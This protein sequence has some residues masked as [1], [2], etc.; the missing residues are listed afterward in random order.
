[1]SPVPPAPPAVGVA[2]V[3]V[4]PSWPQAASIIDALRVNAA[5]RH[6]LDRVFD[7]DLFCLLWFYF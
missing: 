5:I 7:I 6:K 1:L 4:P 3:P 2:L